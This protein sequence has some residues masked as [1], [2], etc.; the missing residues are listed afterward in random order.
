MGPHC[1]GGLGVRRCG[2]VPKGRAQ[3]RRSASQLA[4]N[5]DSVV[6]LDADFGQN[7]GRM[8][9]D[10]GGRNVGLWG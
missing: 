10:R 7:L 6:S 8:L 9:T 2:I 4:A 5:E 3:D 1:Q